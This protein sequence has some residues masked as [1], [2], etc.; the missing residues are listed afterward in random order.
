M[1]NALRK[2]LFLTN[3]EVAPFT[4]NMADQQ[5][6]VSV[7]L[8]RNLNINVRGVKKIYG[9]KYIPPI[10]NNYEMILRR[11]WL[12]QRQV[13]HDWGHSLIT[14]QDGKEKI[15]KNV[16]ENAPVPTSKRA[17]AW[18]NY[19]WKS[20]VFY[21]KKTMVYR[22]FPKLQPII[23]ID[24]CGFMEL[25]K[26]KCHVTTLI[27]EANGQVNSPEQEKNNKVTKGSVTT[28]ANDP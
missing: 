18:K 25:Y 8:I 28:L 7:G 24:S 27:E 26:A 2:R 21:E 3:I 14:L 6:M 22:S 5:E 12:K 19:D 15:I 17:L 1:M 9:N 4:I 13:K 10:D 23:K 16:Q 20:R 11:T